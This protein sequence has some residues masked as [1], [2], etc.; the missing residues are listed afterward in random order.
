VIRREAAPLFDKAVVNYSVI[1]DAIFDISNWIVRER[2]AQF[3][4]V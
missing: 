1:A 2:T 3:R 4:F